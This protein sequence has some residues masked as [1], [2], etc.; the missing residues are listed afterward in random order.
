V[1][2]LLPALAGGALAY[3]LVLVAAG[4]INDRDRGRAADAVAQLRRRRPVATARD[5]AAP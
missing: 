3:V 5:A 4:G 2:G 1:A